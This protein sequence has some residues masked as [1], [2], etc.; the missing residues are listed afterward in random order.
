MPRRRSPRTRSLPRLTAKVVADDDALWEVLNAVV[1]AT[2]GYPRRRRQVIR[3]QERLKD[4]VSE[5]AWNVFIK[6]EQLINERNEDVL[7]NVVR[8]AFEEG[9]P[10]GGQHQG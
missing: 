10:C 1:L 2:P 3:Q 5:E 4:V 6:I 9:R 7:M 8:W